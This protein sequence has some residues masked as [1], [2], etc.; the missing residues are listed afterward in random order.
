MTKTPDLAIRLIVW[1]EIGLYAVSDVM[2]ERLEAAKMK[3]ETVFPSTKTNADLIRSASWLHQP[4]EYVAQAYSPAGRLRTLPAIR[5]K[6]NRRHSSAPLKS[7]V[8]VDS[9][10]RSM[11]GSLRSDVST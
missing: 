3:N 4:G 6:R 11:P 2:N 10:S 9:R 7:G 1:R 5:S 8:F